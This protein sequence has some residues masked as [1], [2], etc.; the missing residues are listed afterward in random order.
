MILTVIRYHP[1]VAGAIL[2]MPRTAVMLAAA[3]SCLPGGAAAG[4]GRSGAGA[5]GAPWR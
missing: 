4:D 2:M 3:C 1:A 5:G